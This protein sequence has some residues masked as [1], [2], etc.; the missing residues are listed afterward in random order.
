MKGWFVGLF[1]FLSCG[2]RAQIKEQLI[3]LRQ[4]LSF[5]SHQIIKL[6]QLDTMYLQEMENR[7]EEAETNYN[8]PRGIQLQ[9]KYCLLRRLRGYQEILTEEQFSKMKKLRFDIYPYKEWMAT[10]YKKNKLST[11]E[12]VVEKEMQHSKE[13][14]SN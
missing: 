14:E 5:S 9:H 8:P 7:K 6:V 4:E 13:K 12:E 11:I 3:Q 2:I 1:V 10:F